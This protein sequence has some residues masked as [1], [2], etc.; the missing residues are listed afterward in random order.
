[1]FQKLKIKLKKHTYHLMLQRTCKFDLLCVPEH[2]PESSKATLHSF[3][4]S[5]PST[6]TLHYF[7]FLIVCYQQAF[8]LVMDRSV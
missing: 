6:F 3:H 2:P 1:V 5:T 7:T 4:L 8:K